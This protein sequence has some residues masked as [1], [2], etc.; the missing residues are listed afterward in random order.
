MKS[1]AKNINNLN[2]QIAGKTGTTNNNGDAWFIDISELTVGV[3]V[4]YDVQVTGR[5]ETGSKV[6]APIFNDFMKKIYTKKDPRPFII[7]KQLNL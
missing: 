5:F 6:A 3:F 1:T 4:G 2:F 7:L